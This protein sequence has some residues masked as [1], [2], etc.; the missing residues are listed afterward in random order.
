M[1]YLDTEGDI[2]GRLQAQDKRLAGGFGQ[3]TGAD[4]RYSW[5]ISNDVF[6]L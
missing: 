2:G 1:T 6:P 5:H 3:D 4:R